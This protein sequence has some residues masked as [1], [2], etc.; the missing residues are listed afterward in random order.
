M[1]QQSDLGHLVMIPSKDQIL[2]RLDTCF[3]TKPDHM[4]HS[5]SQFLL[6]L[7]GPK[8]TTPVIIPGRKREKD[9]LCLES[10]KNINL[11]SGCMSAKSVRT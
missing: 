8:V 9:S 11:K 4:W 5:L 6:D 1:R 7:L 10:T 3:Q 2:K